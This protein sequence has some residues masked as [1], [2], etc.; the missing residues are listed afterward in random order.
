RKTKDPAKEIPGR[1]V[2]EC[3]RRGLI[4]LSAG[5][6]SNVLRFLVPLVIA[7]E[8]L[9]EALSVLEAAFEAVLTDS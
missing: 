9:E 6:Y 4:V 8:E 2:A 7:D 3:C 1:L 5:I